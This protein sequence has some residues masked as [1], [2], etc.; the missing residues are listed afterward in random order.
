ML[1]GLFMSGLHTGS[2]AG[3]SCLFACLPVCLTCAA[4][5]TALRCSRRLRCDHFLS[6]AGGRWN[7]RQAR[8]P[9]QL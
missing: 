6:A 3:Q 7:G 5:L 9:W 2:A 1:P 4:F 8:A